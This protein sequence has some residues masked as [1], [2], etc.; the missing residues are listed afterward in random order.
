MVLVSD[1]LKVY[2]DDLMVREV[3][4][5]GQDE[6]EAFVGVM[7]CSPKG[8]GAKA[9]FTDFQLREGAWANKGA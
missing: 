8:G 3:N 5:F 4:V 6:T 1:S 2:F 7:T 9:T